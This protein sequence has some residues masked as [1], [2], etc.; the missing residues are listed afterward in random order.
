MAF[1]LWE[2]LTDDAGD[3]DHRMFVTIGQPKYTPYA[4]RVQGGFGDE[5]TAFLRKGFEATLLKKP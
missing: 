3:L 1:P 5:A 2:R 4:D